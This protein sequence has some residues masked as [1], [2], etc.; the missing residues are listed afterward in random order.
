MLTRNELK[1]IAIGLGATLALLLF[2]LMAYSVGAEDTR[3][4]QPAPRAVPTSAEA[5]IALAPDSALEPM[6]PTWW[7]ARGT[8]AEL[9]LKDAFIEAFR[10]SANAAI[11]FTDDDLW[12]AA[13]TR[14]DLVCAWES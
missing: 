11:P 1:Y 7:Q 10:Q 2:G 8:T 14:L 3:Q 13:R 4:A 9:I 6:C 12:A 5:V